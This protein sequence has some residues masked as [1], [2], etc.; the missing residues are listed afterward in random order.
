MLYVYIQTYI[1]THCSWAYTGVHRPNRYACMQ[2]DRFFVCLQQ[3]PIAC[4]LGSWAG[5][6]LTCM[7]FAC[8]GPLL[9]Y[10]HR[11]TLVPANPSWN[12]CFLTHATQARDLFFISFCSFRLVFLS[13]RTQRERVHVR[14]RQKKEVVDR[15]LPKM[16][17]TWSLCFHSHTSTPHVYT[18]VYERRKRKPDRYIRVVSLRAQCVF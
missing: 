13:A 9:L 14:N 3:S 6:C 11:K 16:W 15:I 1:F 7:F 10:V 8:D 18:S 12:V 2:E 5:V 4:A 17:Q